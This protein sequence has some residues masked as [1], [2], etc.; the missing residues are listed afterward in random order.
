MQ[1]PK[2]RLGKTMPQHMGTEPKMSLAV[3]YMD[4]AFK[5]FSLLFCA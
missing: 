1:S 5:K 4:C 3:C 2:Q